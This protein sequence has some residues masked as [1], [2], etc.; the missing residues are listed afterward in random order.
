MVPEGKPRMRYGLIGSG[1]VAHALGQHVEEAVGWAGQWSR[2]GM[3]AVAGVPFSA[4][5][6]GWQ[7]AV[8]AVADGALQAVAERV[9][10]GV[11]RVHLSGAQPLDAVAPDGER[12]AVMWPVCSIRKEHA[13]EWSQVHW[14]IEATD[15]EVLEWASALVIRLG[16]TPHPLSHSERLSAHIAAVFAA[17][18]T[19]LMLAEAAALAL[20]SGMPWE[21]FHRLA[22]GVVERSASPAGATRLTGPAARGDEAT[23]AAHVGALGASP[24][25]SALYT[26]LTDSIRTRS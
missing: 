5:W 20:P 4:D 25:L 13:P 24:R 1:H 7:V 11:W 26:A 14:G 8:L 22:L 10:R 15:S 6:S 23:V 3:H 12:G 21:A 9:P 18:F 16:G 19:N 2:S 17:N